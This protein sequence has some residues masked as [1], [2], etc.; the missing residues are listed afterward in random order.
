MLMALF[1]YIC[2]V[3]STE[4]RSR[5]VVVVAV[6]SGLATI[7]SH[8]S[9]GYA[10][11]FLGYAWTF[12]FLLGIIFT[13]LCYTVFILPEVD[14]VSATTTV[15]AVFFTTEHFR[16]VLALYVLDDADGLGRHWKLRFTL[17]VLGV[18]SVVQLGCFDAETLFMLS[19]PLCFTSVWIGYFNVVS[20]FV[21]TLT[22]FIVTHIFVHHV[23]DLILM[24]VG[25]VC[26]TGYELMFGLSTNQV[27]L[28][29]GK[30]ILYSV[31]AIF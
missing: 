8:L 12:V 27:M 20:Y 15:K 18:T 28:F 21:T 13:A 22:N 29:L 19:A 30:Y 16:R 17:L 24:V 9:V 4:S 14:P 2:S 7:V 1:S 31:N 26:G 25:L 3:T 11:H 6:T 10:I 5:R 23:G